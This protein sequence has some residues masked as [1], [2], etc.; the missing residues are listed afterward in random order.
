[1]LNLILERL[2]Q[3][4]RTMRWP[5]G[6]PPALPSRFRGRPRIEAARCT[7]GCRESRS[8]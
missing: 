8:R 3:G 4:Y 1:M 7:A 2:R 6:K 5:R